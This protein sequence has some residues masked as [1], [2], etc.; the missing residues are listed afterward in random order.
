MAVPSCHD[1]GK[2]YLAA[3][4]AAWWISTNRPGDAFV[5][6]SAPT[7]AQVRAILW[8]EIRRAHAKGGLPGRV[9]QTEWLIDGAL[10]GFGRKPGDDDPTAFQGIHARRVLVIFDEACGVPQ[11]LWDAAETLLTNEQSRML[12]I[13]NPDDPD[14]AFARV[15]AP[16]SGWRL[17][18]IDAFDTPNLS[19]E[20]VPDG[21]RPLL[22]SR[23]WVEEQRLRWGEESPLWLAKVRGQFPPAAE[24]GLFAPADL[25]A[26]VARDLAAGKPVELG[27]DVARFGGDETV[28]ALRE[29][30]VGRIF[31]AARGLDLMTTVGR[32]VEAA[33]RSGAVAIKVDDS[34]VGGGVTDRLAE[35]GLPVVP[36][37]GAS[38]PRDP[39]RFLNLRAEI[40]WALVERARSGDLRLEADEA[41]LGQLAKLRHGLTSRGQIKIESKDDMRRRG[42]SS[43]DRADAL[44]LAFATK[45]AAFRWELF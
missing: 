31:M 30:A 15:C 2:S 11:S 34:G 42:L 40:L 24:G 27:V 12:A 44:A 26:A 38:R 13:G 25:R 1:A 43:P 32:V 4:L 7:F 5:V 10:V 14:G 16:G 23:A 36:I 17:L 21:L 8:R 19:G 41:L 3:R 37:N 9:N 29:G 18:P 33:R 20:A 6:T 28:I 35:L 45:P 22:I 39:E